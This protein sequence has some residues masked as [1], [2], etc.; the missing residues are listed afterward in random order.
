[1][2]TI[3]LLCRRTHRLL[4]FAALG[5][6]LSSV[7]GG[8]SGLGA[9][10]LLF[11]AEDT[12]V[13]RLE[14][15]AVQGFRIR[16]VAEDS[17][18]RI[19][20]LREG[21]LVVS[22]NG[23]PVN[24][25]PLTA[26]LRPGQKLVVGLLRAGVPLTVDLG[27]AA[28]A[29]L[30]AHGVPPKPLALGVPQKAPSGGIPVPAQKPAPG[31]VV[32][33]ISFPDGTRL[34]GDIVDQAIAVQGVSAMGE[35]VSFAPV[36]GPDG[37]YRQRV[38]PGTYSVSRAVVTL[39]HKGVE[40]RVPLEPVGNLADKSRDSDAGIVQDFVWNVTGPT[41]RSRSGMPNVNESGDWNGAHIRLT[42]QTYQQGKGGTQAPPDGTQL[43][44]TVRPV[45]PTLDGRTLEPFVL[46][47]VWRPGKPTPVEDLNDLP[48]ADYE[49]TG[50]ARFPDGTTKPILFQGPEDRPRFVPVLKA[51]LLKGGYVG[52][53][54][55]TMAGFVIE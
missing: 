5:G 53:F 50:E 30:A 31:F 47:R 41:S 38:S 46:E 29:A 11:Q 7:S 26:G 52:A 15:A 16:A 27:E 12:G 24:G 55:P 28:A 2:I 1:M 6:L 36:V 13:P 10:G 37:T 45:S 3:P 22:V 23:V 43:R 17:L 20:G 32:G 51:P 42:W 21:D 48:P 35:R 19:A 9:F 14:A 49:V 40:Y 33:R 18:A 44:Y 8:D 4:V 25:E 54:S 34:T 39:R